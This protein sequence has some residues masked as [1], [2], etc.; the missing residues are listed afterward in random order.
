MFF[1]SGSNLITY[2]FFFKRLRNNLSSISQTRVSLLTI[3]IA[4]ATSTRQANKMSR[5]FMTLFPWPLLEDVGGI[6][7]KINGTLKGIITYQKYYKYKNN[8]IQDVNTNY[9]IHLTLKYLAVL[10]YL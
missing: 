1:Y 7:W 10:N 8:K 2:L 9:T 5:N 6:F 3:A 4:I